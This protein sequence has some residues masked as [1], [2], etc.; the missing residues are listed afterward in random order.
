MNEECDR[1]N[2]SAAK[3][4]KAGLIL[5]GLVLLI[6]LFTPMRGAE[7]DRLRQATLPEPT[8]Q[9]LTA[10]VILSGST[11]VI[12]NRSDMDWTDLVLRINS[13]VTP[14]GFTAHLSKLNAGE[15]GYLPAGEFADAHAMRFNP[16]THKMTDIVIG[17][18]TK[19]GRGVYIGVFPKYTHADS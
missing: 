11:L 2:R 18:W 16:F 6:A 15:R 8:F 10:E 5:I 9:V 4:I 1:P 7:Q 12:V 17:A 13:K 3:L 19:K 14:E